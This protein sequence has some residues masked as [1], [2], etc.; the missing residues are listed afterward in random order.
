[1]VS[2]GGGGG[3]LVNFSQ[4]KCWVPVKGIFFGGGYDRVF[5]L[6]LLHLEMR[7]I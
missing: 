2:W 1:M 3:V 5:F 4:E 7:L 6:D